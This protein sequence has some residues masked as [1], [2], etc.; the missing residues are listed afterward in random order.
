[1]VRDSTKATNIVLTIK[2]VVEQNIDKTFER[3][4]SSLLTEEELKIPMSYKKQELSLFEFKRIDKPKD[5]N[6]E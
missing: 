1:M 5:F 4:M 2:I 6:R 3:K